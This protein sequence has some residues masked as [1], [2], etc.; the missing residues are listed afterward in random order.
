MTVK[1]PEIYHNDA[2]VSFYSF[3]SIE[4]TTPR[5]KQNVNYRLWV[6]MVYQ[7]RLINFNKC[8]S[9]V[10]DVNS[11]GIYAYVVNTCTFFL[12]FAV[13]LKLL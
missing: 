6:I 4:C 13:N 9:L 7:C 2:H 12:N 11:E 10:G 3:K 5:V 1:T 8:T